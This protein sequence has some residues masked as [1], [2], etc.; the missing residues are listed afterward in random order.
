MIDG[1]RVIWFN[2]WFSQAF[3]FVNMLKRDD[4]NYVI[5]S[6]KVEDFIFGAYA[7]ERHIEPRGVTGDQYVEW[8][9]DFC[10]EHSVDVF[11]AK[12]WAREVI[13]HIDE[14]KAVGTTLISDK[15][16]DI[17]RMLESKMDSCEYMKKYDL[18]PTPY[19]ERITTVAGLETAYRRVK[20]RYG[21]KSYVCVKADVDEGGLTYKRLCDS[22]NGKRSFDDVPYNAFAE[23]MKRREA[24]R[25]KLRPMVVM[26]YLEEPEVSIDCMNIKG[27]LI[28]IPRIKTDVHITQLRFDERFIKTAERISSKLHI[29]YPYNIQLRPLNGE[30]VFMEINTRMA[31][32]SYKADAVGCNFP[33]LAVSYAFGD[34]IDVGRIKAGFKDKK[35][36]EAAIYVE[37]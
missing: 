16:S 2:H 17:I 29:E 37:L 6:A 14:F 1:K 22:T 8:C 30:Y 7:D 26:P 35:I 11:F 15:N 18:C 24:E 25:G 23:D 10:R 21:E 4:R 3:N 27:E 20:E 33:Q 34:D 32:G 12:R 19:M 36:G 13:K 9:I 5:A 31:G 28:A